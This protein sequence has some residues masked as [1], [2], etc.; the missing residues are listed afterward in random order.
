MGPTFTDPA[1][2]DA[3]PWPKPEASFAQLVLIADSYLNKN[4]RGERRY[5]S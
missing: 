3:A 2:P 4:Y 5:P 1:R